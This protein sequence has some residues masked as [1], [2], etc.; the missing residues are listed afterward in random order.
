MDVIKKCICK[1]SSRGESWTL[2]GEGHKHAMVVGDAQM[3]VL[4]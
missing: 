2:Q 4:W 3:I 1:G